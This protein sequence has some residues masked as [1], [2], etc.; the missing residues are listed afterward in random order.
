MSDS[1]RSSLLKFLAVASM[2]L[3]LYLMYESA[4]LYY[5]YQFGH[6]LFF[7]MYAITTLVLV[8]VGGLLLFAFG[9]F[10]F[11]RQ[12]KKDKIRKGRSEN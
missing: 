12:V 5:Q 7:Y 9:L 3:G 2:S 6:I 4:W 8:F 11:I 10:F 1:A